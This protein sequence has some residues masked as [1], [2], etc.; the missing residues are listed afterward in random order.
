VDRGTPREVQAAGA[1][2]PLA[3]TLSSAI[4]RAPLHIPL[5]PTS[6]LCRAPPCS[7]RSGRAPSS[8]RAVLPEELARYV[9]P[10]VK[11]QWI[12]RPS[13]TSFCPTSAS[14]V[15]RLCA[16]PTPCIL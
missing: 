3:Y 11:K 8:R 10:A 1:A 2:V 5:R 16:P 4:L 7:G 13:S 14:I 15:H 6:T 12:G 9:A